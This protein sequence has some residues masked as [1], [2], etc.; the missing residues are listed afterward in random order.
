MTES[1][2]GSQGKAKIKA[3]MIPEKK[4]NVIYDRRVLALAIT[5]G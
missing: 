2:K 3:H 4:K 5:L 1:A